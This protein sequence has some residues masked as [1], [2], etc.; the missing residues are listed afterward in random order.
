MMEKPNVIV[1]LGSEK[2][3]DHGLSILKGLHLFGIE[4]HI[5]IASAHKDVRR[6]L[7][8][9]ESWE[10]TPGPKV[11]I[12]VAGKSNALSAIVDANTTCPVIACPPYSEA[13]AGADLYSSLRLPSGIA[14]AVVLEPF[15]A[16]LLA[17][18]MLSMTNTALAQSISAF[19][20]QMREEARND[21]ECLQSCVLGWKQ[22]LLES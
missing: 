13:F 10:K 17:I 7:E 4:G 5:Q 6:L 2:D 11:Y 18:K 16:A 9:L 1:F 14:P 8:L 15:A 20:R 3:T 22:G 12:T 21:D 19:Q